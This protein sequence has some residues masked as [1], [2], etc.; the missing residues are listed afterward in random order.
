MAKFLLS[1]TYIYFHHCL[2][3]FSF[4]LPL[5]LKETKILLQSI[6]NIHKSRRVILNVQVIYGPASTTSTKPNTD[7]CRPLSTLRTLSEASPIIY[8]VITSGFISKRILKIIVI[9]LPKPEKMNSNSLL[10]LFSC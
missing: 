4:Y 5:T 2:T 9:P 1:V 8:F 7:L 3:F 6:S 10:S